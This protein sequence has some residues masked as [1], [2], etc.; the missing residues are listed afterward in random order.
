MIWHN[1]QNGR[2]LWSEHDQHNGQH[3]RLEASEV[4]P[5]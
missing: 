2:L 3:G 5:Q 4:D 1:G